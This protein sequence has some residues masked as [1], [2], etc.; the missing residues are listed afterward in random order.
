MNRSGA[1]RSGE[2]QLPL[3][4]GSGTTVEMALKGGEVGSRAKMEGH[5]IQSGVGP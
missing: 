5:G 3:P 2:G 1:I 4:E